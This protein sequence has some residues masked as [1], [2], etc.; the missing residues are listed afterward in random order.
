MYCNLLCGPE[1]PLYC[2]KSTTPK[3]KKLNP[4]S[5]GC[6]K[7]FYGLCRPVNDT[8]RDFSLVLTDL[9]RTVRT[10]VDFLIISPNQPHNFLIFEAK[11]SAGTFRF[12][13]LFC[14]QN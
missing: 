13:L 14:S 2:T 11:Y 6:K 4:G 8:T 5:L 1:K 3:A 12:V 7:N 9:I 10:K